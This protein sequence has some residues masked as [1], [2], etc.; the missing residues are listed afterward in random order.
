MSKRNK[1]PLAD[2]RD[3]LRIVSAL[4]ENLLVEAA[5]G[6]GKT[7]SLAQRMTSGIATGRY[8]VEEMAAITFTRKAA[9]ELRGRFQQALED[10]LRECSPE[11]RASSAT[12]KRVDGAERERETRRLRD[13]LAGIE[14]LFA[15]TIHSFCAHLLRERPVEAHLA[16]GFDEIDETSDALART[17]AWNA[18]VARARATGSP[19]LLALEDAGV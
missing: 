8:R 10:R 14:R 16:P 4:D 15:G 19:L 2:E 18:F 17:E 9:A 6:S 7:H 12:G 11:G 5:A 13:A 3:R 1:A